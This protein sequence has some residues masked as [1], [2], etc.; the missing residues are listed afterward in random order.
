VPP[1]AE[2][3]TLYAAKC[4]WPGVTQDELERAGRAAARE[5]ERTPPSETVRYLGSLVFVNDELVLCLYE[6][7]SRAAVKQVNERAGVPCERLM[8][9][10]WLAHPRLETRTR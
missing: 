2:A 1:S 3:P 10:L 8:E 4:Y 6:S 5:T 9:A 7:S